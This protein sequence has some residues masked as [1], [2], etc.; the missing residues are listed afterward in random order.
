[1]RTLKRAYQFL[2]PVVNPANGELVANTVGEWKCAPTQWGDGKCDCNCGRADWDCMGSTGRPQE[3]VTEYLTATAPLT[4]ENVRVNI[5]CPEGSNRK[6]NPPGLAGGSAFPSCG[7]VRAAAEEYRF[8]DLLTGLPTKDASRAYK[9]M[10]PKEPNKVMP[11]PGMTTP[12][13]NFAGEGVYRNRAP[14]PSYMRNLW[15]SGGDK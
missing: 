2:F 13:P 8:C 11:L 14:A 15:E 1:V 5:N 12:D 10:D 6:L 4:D 3:Y 7:E 9:P